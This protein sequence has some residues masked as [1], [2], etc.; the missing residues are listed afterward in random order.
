MLLQFT[1]D[2]FKSEETELFNKACSMGI[3]P[4]V[5]R[6]LTKPTF[7]PNIYI[8]VSRRPRK[9]IDH[10]KLPIYATGRQ[11]NTFPNSL[12]KQSPQNYCHTISRSKGG[13]Q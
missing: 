1:S 2:F 3:T 6:V 5:E 8:P 9:I 11:Y 13:R 10:T 4:I 7:N 12:Q